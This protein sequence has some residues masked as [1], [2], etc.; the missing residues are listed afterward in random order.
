MLAAEEDHACPAADHGSAFFQFVS[1][2]LEEW[3]QFAAMFAISSIIN[4]REDTFAQPL[5]AA[6]KVHVIREIIMQGNWSH[7]PQD[8]PLLL[9]LVG[10][11]AAFFE[12][13]FRL[14]I[15]IQRDIFW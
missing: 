4:I 10:Q 8:D 14:G 2:G 1:M 7:H 12:I 11:V 5:H 13:G 15:L 3:H 9:G 6:I